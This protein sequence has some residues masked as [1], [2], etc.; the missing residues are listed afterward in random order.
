MNTADILNLA[1]AAHDIHGY[2]LLAEHG[3]HGSCGGAWVVIPGRGNF[4]KQAKG[5][6][7]FLFSHHTG[8]IALRFGRIPTQSE[9]INASA[10]Q[11]AADTLNLYGIKA[12]VYS[13][14]D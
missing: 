14:I 11:A 10:A 13:Y 9:W 2:A 7:Y 1:S 5:T 12:R 3:D 8:G 6:S 4:A